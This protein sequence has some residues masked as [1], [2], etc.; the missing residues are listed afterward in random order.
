MRSVKKAVVAAIILVLSCLRHD[1]PFDIS[2][3]NYDPPEV[4]IAFDTVQDG[5]TIARAAFSVSLSGNRPEVSVRWRLDSLQWTPWGKQG[6]VLIDGYDTGRH[7][8]TAQGW[9][10]EGGEVDSASISFVKV[11]PP[12]VTTDTASLLDDSLVPVTAGT[13][14]TLMVHAEGSGELSFFW[15]HD[16]ALIDTVSGN[17]LV[18]GPFIESDTGVY[19]VIVHNKWEADTSDTVFLRYTLPANHP[20]VAAGDSFTVEEDGELNVTTAQSILKNDSDVDEYELMAV[21]VDSTRNGELNLNENGTFSYKPDKDFWGADSFTYKARDKKNALSSTVTVQLTITAVNDVPEVANNSTVTLNEGQRVTIAAATLSVTDID[22]SASEI[23]Y[24]PTRLPTSGSLLLDDTVKSVSGMFTQKNID[25]GNVAYGHDGS[26]TRA[27]TAIFSVRDGNGGQI[28][29]V[30]L[31]FDITPVN[32]TPYFATKLDLVVTEGGTKTISNA[33]LQVKD[34]DNTPAELLFTVGSIAVHGSILKNGTTLDAGATFTQQ[35]IDSDRIVYQHDKSNTTRDSLSFTVNDGSGGAIEVT[36]LV[37][38]IGAVD[39]PPV[40]IDQ[41]VS[42]NEDTP[43]EITLTATDP[44][45][46]AISGWEIARQPGHG[47][48]SGSGSTRTYAPVQDFFGEDTFLFRGNDGVNWSDTGIIAITVLPV[49]DA[50]AWK[51]ASVELAGKEGTTITLDLNTVFDKDPEGDQVT[52]SKKAG[53]G[54]ITGNTWSWSPGFAAAASS[55]AGCVITAT[56]NGSPAKSADITLNITVNDSLCKLT[57][58]VAIGS[59][60]VQVQPTGTLFDPGTEVQM[61]ANPETDYVFKNWTGDVTETDRNN[62]TVQILMNTDKNVKA[63]FVKAIETIIINTTG[64]NFNTMLYAEGYLFAFACSEPARLARFNIDNLADYSIVELPFR[65]DACSKMSYSTVTGKLYLFWGT[66]YETHVAEIDP[67]NLTYNG[68]FIKDTSEG[69]IHGA[70]TVDN[71]SIYLVTGRYVSRKWT[72]ATVR[73][74][75]LHS[76]STEPQATLLLDSSCI[77]PRTVQYK[78]GILYIAGNGATGTWF[79]RIRTSDMVILDKNE[80]VATGVAEQSAITDKHF[81]LGL[82]SSGTSDQKGLIYRIENNNA[83]LYDIA[84]T[85]IGSGENR[86]ACN[87]LC[88]GIDKIFGTFSSTT[89]ILSSI[90]PLALTCNNYRLD[91]TDPGAIISDGKRIFVTYDSQSSPIIQALYPQ[92]L[93]DREIP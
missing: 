2:A 23:I 90:D 48:I 79:T 20:P 6:V 35:D 86:V 4:F 12:T 28:D 32:D 3:P 11:M 26:E 68:D 13:R 83:M 49:N 60:T 73:K 65:Q 37:T 93:N 43:L 31:P 15:Y 7:V 51:Q 17:K 57:V 56:D 44:E 39:D 82:S 53:A 50:P 63:V 84:D 21:M 5:D 36:W 40:A 72:P 67:F 69:L 64:F 66:T 34:N 14:C 24:T 77:K 16:S 59:G 46:V 1:N 41:G 71:S 76:P 25:D 75:G 88:K 61:T 55:P 80:I 70:I 29:T 74:Y 18:V 85:K 92:Y 47:T 78:E 58:S 52:F 30:L 81:F 8:I 27:D 54:S 45:G 22:N 42:T 9:Y 87:A 19:F 62:A 89:G 38:R 10:G 33:T 91:Y